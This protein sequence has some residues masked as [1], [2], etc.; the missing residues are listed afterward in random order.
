MWDSHFPQWCLWQ[1]RLEPL[2]LVGLCFAWPAVYH[3]WV[4]AGPLALLYSR[5]GE[6]S[7][8]SELGEFVAGGSIAPSWRLPPSTS[9]LPA[10]SQTSLR[11]LAQDVELKLVCWVEPGDIPWQGLAH[12]SGLYGRRHAMRDG[13]ALNQGLPRQTRVVIYRLTA[14]ESSTRMKSP[15]EPTL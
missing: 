2:C 15:F 4:V 13:A 14:L 5:S 10:L 6:K 3:G 1:F 12:C 11:S 8:T 7:R 9:W